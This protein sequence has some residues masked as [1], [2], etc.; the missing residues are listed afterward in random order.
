MFSDNFLREAT[1]PNNS[2]GARQILKRDGDRDPDAG[3]VA[4]IQVIPVGVIEIDIVGLIPRRGPRF[5]P[6]IDERNPVAVVLE[7]RIASYKEQRKAADPEEMVGA[8]I[9]FEAIVG[10]PVPVIAAALLPGAVVS[11]PR[12]G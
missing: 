9:E 7:T 12:T 10:N 2:F 8:E 4:V 11:V 5:R 6:W 3:V 1:R